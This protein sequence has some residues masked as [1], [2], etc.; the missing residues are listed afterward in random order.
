MSLHQHFGGST[1][2]GHEESGGREA[3][4]EAFAEVFGAESAI[5]RGQ[6]SPFCI[7]VSL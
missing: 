1:G 3:L 5:V 7:V 6:V 2:Y 4:D